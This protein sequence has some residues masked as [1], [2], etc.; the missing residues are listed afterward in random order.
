MTM[1]SIKE[2]LEILKKVQIED[3]QIYDLNVFIAAMPHRIAESQA[4]FETKKQKFNGLEE[5]LKKLKLAVKD[6]ELELGKKDGEIKRLD[7]QL[8]SVKTNK[9]YSAIQSEIA[10][11][12]ADK[13]MLEEKLIVDWEVIEKLNASKESEKKILAAE[14]SKFNNEKKAIEEEGSKAK[15][16]VQQLIQERQQILQP[17][18]KEVRDLYEKIL[19]K[20]EGVAIVPTTQDEICGGCRV[21]LRPQILNEVRMLEKIV[22]CESCSRILYYPS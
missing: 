12:K 21:R 16:K 2:E 4:E 22:V 17:L 15:E 19:S 14:E 1:V 11:I 10:G 6:K 13:G 18:E 5:E 9:E 7:G 3:K 20:R 8:G